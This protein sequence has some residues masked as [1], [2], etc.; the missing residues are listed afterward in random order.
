[1]NESEELQFR[2]SGGKEVR[3]FNVGCCM[4]YMNYE[5]RTLK[6]ILAG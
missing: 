1:M 3:A 4:P 2:R 5:P 6:E